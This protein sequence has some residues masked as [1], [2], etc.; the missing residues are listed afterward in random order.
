MEGKIL[1]I[2]KPKGITSF[3][4]IRKLRQKLNIRKMGHAGT[5]DPFATGLLIVAIGSATKKLTEFLKLP[6]TYETEILFGIQTDT[7]DITG[8]ILKDENVSLD[9]EKVK[10][11]LKDVVG[12]LA[13]SV[14]AY[15]AIK[16]SGEPLYKKARAGEVFETPVKNMEIRRVVFVDLYK[17]DDKAVLKALFDVG[18]GTYIR[19]LAEEIGKRLGVPAT[20]R[21]LR[22]TQIGDMNIEQAERIDSIQA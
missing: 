3:D 16:V 10:E 5:L 12:I 1:L 20:V 19:S 21:E 11:V 7:G 15:S 2:D 9:I 18:S 8:K 17:E 22:R 6:K 14:P 13:L 4:V